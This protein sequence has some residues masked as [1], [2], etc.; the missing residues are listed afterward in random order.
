MKRFDELSEQE[1]L[2]LAISLEEDDERIYAD[3]AEGL[4]ENY[5][6][7]AEVFDGM[8]EE[9]AGHRRRL[10]E[11]YRAKFGE[12]IPL[13]RRHDVQGFLHRSP[14]WLARPMRIDKIRAQVSLME[15]ETRRF[16]KNRRA[17]RGMPASGSC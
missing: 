6:G 11:M 8:R 7:S 5:P 1:I 16:M 15:E 4:R 14:I 12:H 13:I 10:I 17:A 2:A 9:E 3:Y